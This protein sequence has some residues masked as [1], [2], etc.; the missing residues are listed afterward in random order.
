[1]RGIQLE[2]AETVQDDL[3]QWGMWAFLCPSRRLRYPS[4]QS[5]TIMKAGC[6]LR[7]TDEH[8]ERIDRTIARLYGRDGETIDVLVLFY[9]YRQSWRDIE[10]LSGIKRTKAQT[11]LDTAK[12]W[13]GGALYFKNA[14]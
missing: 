1:M 13:I 10:R 4:Y 2:Y 6:S 7:I 8:A 3:E 11:I 12:G 9:I 5:W 14:G